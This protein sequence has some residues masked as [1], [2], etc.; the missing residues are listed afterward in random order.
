[1]NGITPRLADRLSSLAESQ[2]QIQM[3]R[4][5]ALDAGALGVMGVDVAVAAI[6]LAVGSADYLWVA[7]LLLLCISLGVAI[8]VLRL[9][10]A[11]QTGPL[12]ANVLAERD[13]YED[14]K[15][16]ESVLE[17]L[18]AETL[19]NRRALTRKAPLLDRA[20]I[21]L[22]LAIAVEMAGRVQ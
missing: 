15:L 12:V 11:E 4:S 2:L 1:M 3:S 5:A 20:L 17:R 16:E 14:G 10:G 18:A 7:A 21:S 13:S 19:G 22:V 9:A 8:R 6:I